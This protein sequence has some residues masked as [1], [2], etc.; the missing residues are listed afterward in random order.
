[1]NL[2]I[3]FWHQIQSIIENKIGIDLSARVNREHFETI[4]SRSDLISKLKKEEYLTLL[5]T[6][7]PS[8]HPEWI[9]LLD[10]LNV[11]ESFFFRDKKQL[12]LIEN[13]I[14]PE[15]IR[16]KSSDTIK[17]WSAGCS[18]GQEPYTL[19]IIVEKIKKVFPDS[20]FVIYAS[21]I[22]FHSIKIAT[23]AFYHPWSVR[24][25]D[26]TLLEDFFEKKS[27]KYR[28]RYEK[29]TPV[30]FELINLVSDP[31]PKNFDLIICRNVF[32]YMKP[33]FIQRVIEKFSESLNISG[34]LLIGHAEF[35][36]KMPDSLDTMLF[37]NSVI[38]K[39][40]SATQ[41]DSS[42][43]TKNF[44]E[45]SPKFNPNKSEK[46]TNRTESLWELESKLEKANRL[47]NQN[48]IMN[49]YSKV[50]SSLGK[51]SNKS[52]LYFIKNFSK[53]NKPK[54]IHLCQYMIE[55]DPLNVQGYF[56][57]AQVY[58]SIGKIDLAIDSYKKVLYLNPTHKETHVCLFQL[59]KAKNDF[60]NAIKIRKMAT[61]F[62]ADLKEFEF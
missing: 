43:L 57:L 17:I 35:S 52:I 38:Y 6:A 24:I 11:S 9:F 32:I 10:A 54:A 23:E 50:E 41:I 14:L 34:Y 33:E 44:K 8:H 15:L 37:A 39:K 20:Q 27:E 60:D 29:V 40:K 62:S 18:T 19:A 58:E 4:C 22:N 31:F 59:Y 45:P 12:E 55:S 7:D 56:H 5:E 49:I 2:D 3:P 42:I 25:S 46:I 61:Q 16:K 28:F 36:G 30:R 21:D 48:E 53:I 47:E 26:Q 1:M 51:L 13:L